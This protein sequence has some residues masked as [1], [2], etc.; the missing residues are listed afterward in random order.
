VLPS[1][2]FQEYELITPVDVEMKFT[3]SG[4]TPDDLSQLNR[5]M[6]GGVDTVIA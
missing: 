3:V 5:A 6:G 4:A 1:P 2:K